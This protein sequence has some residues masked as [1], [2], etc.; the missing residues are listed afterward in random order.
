MLPFSRRRT[1]SFR[2]GEILLEMGFA[3]CEIHVKILSHIL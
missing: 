2:A 3:R 1:N